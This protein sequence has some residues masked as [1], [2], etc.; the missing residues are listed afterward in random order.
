[1]ATEPRKL[2]LDEIVENIGLISIDDEADQPEISTVNLEESAIGRVEI[3]NV[4]VGEPSE[5]DPHRRTRV[6]SLLAFGLLI[7]FGLTILIPALPWLWCSYPDP[8]ALEYAK[9]IASMEIGLLGAAVA[10]Y[11][12][13]TKDEM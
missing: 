10:F 13:E 5:P 8:R 12:R 2:Y 11:Y 4:D 3:A 9:S 1:M 6:A 7:I